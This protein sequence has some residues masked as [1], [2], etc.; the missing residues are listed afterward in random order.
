MPVARAELY[1]TFDIPEKMAS[2]TAGWMG[3]VSTSLSCEAAT[4][5]ADEMADTKMDT[6]EAIP[7]HGT[8]LLAAEEEEEEGIPAW[9][10]GGF[11]MARRSSGRG[12]GPYS[13]RC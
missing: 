4:M 7:S 13:E 6:K 12:L 11:P 1:A 3:H 8:H 5:I 2:Q 9:L 10:Y